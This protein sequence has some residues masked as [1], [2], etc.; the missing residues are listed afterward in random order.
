[1]F[2]G[3]DMAD[4]CRMA[5]RISSSTASFEFVSGAFRLWVVVG[6]A[7]PFGLGVALERL[8]RRR[9]YQAALRVKE[10]RVFLR[11]AALSNNH[12]CQ[13]WRRRS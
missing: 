5:A 13:L 7:V 2:R 9:A 12:R 3:K 11:H 1:M 10:I 4:P 6:L 8:D